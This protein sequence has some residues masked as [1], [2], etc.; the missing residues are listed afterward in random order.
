[1]FSL[2]ENLKLDRGNSLK[3]K[4]ATVLLE[5]LKK[6]LNLPLNPVVK[7]E[8]S[9]PLDTCPFVLNSNIC[10]NYK[11]LKF[12]DW[13]SS[14]GLEQKSSKSSGF[15]SKQSNSPALSSINPEEED[16][17]TL[18]LTDSTR[19]TKRST[20]GF[21]KNLKVIVPSSKYAQNKSKVTFLCNL[22]FLF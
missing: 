13:T 6:K 22:I 5:E 19:T 9:S 12:A 10:N 7:N 21:G 17:W 1:M 4:E 20:S 18:S 3:M 11:I 8:T 16:N 14:S 15:G 2:I